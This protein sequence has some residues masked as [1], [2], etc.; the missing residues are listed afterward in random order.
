M[1]RVIVTGGSGKLGRATVRD[2]LDHGYDVINADAVPSADAAA[3][4]FV[5]VDFED[6]HA[7]MEALAGMDW[8]HTRRVDAVVHLAAIPMPGRLPSGEVF[9]INTMATYNVF[10]ACRRLGIKN[11]VWASSETLLGI[12]YATHPPY[13]PVDED[14]PARP[15]TAYSLSKFL[16][17]QMAEQFCRW[18]PELKIIGL[19]FSNVMEPQEYAEFPHFESNPGNRRFNL[20]SY[21]D[22]RDG[23]QA[24]RKAIEY[25]SKGADVFVIANADGVMSRSN[26][27]LVAEFYPGVPFKHPVTDHET[28]L[29][30]DKARRVLGYEPVHSWRT[31]VT[32]W[33]GA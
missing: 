33:K 31:E 14:Y 23:A 7:T 2:L 21:I 18:D 25:Q 17:E 10:E 15:E 32:A 6:L 26:A 8:D 3:V 28:L 20:W 19:R 16:G 13:L 1:T 12:P 27:K 24:I 22:A 29:S 30:I 9:R 11:V 5:K 4:P